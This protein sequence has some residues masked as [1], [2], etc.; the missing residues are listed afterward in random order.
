M[1]V[2]NEFKPLRALPTHSEFAE[3]D[4]L[5]LF[6]ELFNRGYANGLVEE[7][8]KKGMKII[9]STVG[10]RDKEDQLRNLNA[11]ELA[12]LNYPVINIPLEAGFD[13][14]A[15][16]NGISPV[17]QLKEATSKNWQDYKLDWNAIDESRQVGRSRFILNAGKYMKELRQHIPPGKNVLFAHLMAGGV[18][19]A[20]IIL[21]LMNRVFKGQGDRH[22]SSKTF[23]ES[24]IG[25][26][27][28]MSFNEVTCETFRCLVEESMD[29][30]NEILHNKGKVSYLAY[31]YHGTE[32]FI[33]NELQWQTYTPYLQGFAKVGLENLAHQFHQQKIHCTVYNCPEI[34]TN[35]SSI[36]PGVEMSLYIIL[37]KLSEIT[38]APKYISD[39]ISESK[40]RLKDE[41]ALEQL[42]SLLNNFFSSPHI[43]PH[44]TFDSSWPHHSSK[45][46]MDFML[47]ISDQILEMH[48]SDKALMTQVLSEFIIKAC[49][50]VM[51]HYSYDPK[52]A[53]MWLGH[54]ILIKALQ[55]V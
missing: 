2:S 24:D 38:P 12:E 22:I 54:D 52:E 9:L 7:A 27:T 16:R 46:Q 49:G 41:V 47:A 8:A 20:K 51:L 5:I 50:K 45:E 44:N 18:P 33:N 14:E 17:G 40:S 39:I 15:A 21:L 13:L 31:G 42:E 3:G 10:R 19:R 48:K 55:E 28:A 11:E 30:R 36:F 35:S 37:K 25:K 43:K 29:L 23:W 1:S 34:V 26:F 4:V 6:G 32:A 53:V